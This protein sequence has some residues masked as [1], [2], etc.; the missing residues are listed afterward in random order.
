MVKISKDYF[1]ELSQDEALQFVSKKEKIINSQ[2]EK[3]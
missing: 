2:V 1:V 3:I